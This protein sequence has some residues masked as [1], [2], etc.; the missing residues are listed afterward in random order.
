VAPETAE[1]V[2]PETAESV[3]PETAEEAGA[4]SAPAGQSGALAAVVPAPDDGT[5]ESAA[6]APEG[7]GTQNPGPG[8]PGR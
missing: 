8:A 7:E 1:S 3:A 6:E 5:R 4:P 2:A